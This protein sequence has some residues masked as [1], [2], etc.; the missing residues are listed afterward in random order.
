MP[1]RSTPVEQT[2]PA[3]AKR[4]RMSAERLEQ[5]ARTKRLEAEEFDRKY[6]AYCAQR[7]AETPEAAA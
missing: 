2:W 6:A 1:H 5:Q 4:K 7:D 3:R